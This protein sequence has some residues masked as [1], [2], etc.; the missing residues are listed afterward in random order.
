MAVFA[1]GTP[2]AGAKA[3]RGIIRSRETVNDFNNIIGSKE[4]SMRI[5]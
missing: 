1:A 5:V 4:F 3:Q 2:P